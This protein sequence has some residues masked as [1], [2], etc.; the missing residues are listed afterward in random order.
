MRKSGEKG[1]ERD[2]LKRKFHLEERGT[3]YVSGMLKEKIKA[4]GLKIK[5]DDEKCQ[6]FKQN[7]LFRTTQKLFYEN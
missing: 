6:Q 2:R 3:M 5:R 4:G 1:R 7:H